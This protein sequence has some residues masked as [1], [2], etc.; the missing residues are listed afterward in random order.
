MQYI[1]HAGL[2]NMVSMLYLPYSPLHL[3]Y[4]SLTSPMYLPYISPISPLSLQALRSLNGGALPPPAEPTQPHYARCTECAGEACAGLLRGAHAALLDALVALLD[5]KRRQRRR[6]WQSGDDDA[7]A[8][9][10]AEGAP[11]RVLRDERAL[12]LSALRLLHAPPSHAPLGGPELRDERGGGEERGGVEERL[13][14]L[15]EQVE[16]LL[17]LRVLVLVR[18]HQE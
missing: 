18:V 2:A 17:R 13:V 6:R 15:L 8:A 9:G 7:A 1:S 12:R 10:A 14:G 11:S 4:I 3:P 5:E 16:G